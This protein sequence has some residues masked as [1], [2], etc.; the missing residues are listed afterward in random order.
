MAT[1]SGPFEDV[2][3]IENR[4]FPASHV[5]SS[6]LVFDRCSTWWFQPIWKHDY[7]T[8]GDILQKLEDFHRNAWNRVSSYCVTVGKTRI[9]LV[10]SYRENQKWLERTKDTNICWLWTAASHHTCILKAHF[11]ICQ[12]DVG[13]LDFLTGRNGILTPD[14]WMA[15]RTHTCRPWRQSFRANNLSKCISCITQRIIT[16]TNPVGG[17][18]S[19][20]GVAVTCRGSSTQCKLHIFHVS[21]A[22]R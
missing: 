8:T 11:T 21:S 13:L 3:P 1:E 4:C 10:T 19:L 22:A 9:K 2:S 7:L 12:V 5:T 20:S 17:S 6:S 18:A 16:Q 15:F 14:T